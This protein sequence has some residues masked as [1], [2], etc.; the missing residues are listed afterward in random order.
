MLERKVWRRF[1]DFNS[2]E[3]MFYEYSIGG[4]EKGKEEKSLFKLWKRYE[5]YRSF[6]RFFRHSK[7]IFGDDEKAGDEVYS[8]KIVSQTRMMNSLRICSIIHEYAA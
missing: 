2:E 7:S 4:G 1:I 3:M 6:T 8:L 5:F